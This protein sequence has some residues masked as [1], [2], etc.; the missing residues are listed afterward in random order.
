M[1]KQ[2]F[3]TRLCPHGGAALSSSRRVRPHH[4][5][6]NEQQNERRHHDAGSAS[7]FVLSSVPSSEPT[8]DATSSDGTNATELTQIAF[9]GD[10]DNS[11]VQI[12]GL[13]VT[14]DWSDFF[15][16]PCREGNCR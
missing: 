11:R 12:D 6:N 13:I 9:R 16:S 1:G 4:D 7:L 5:W 8:A 15:V 3:Q 10:S 14:T 2:F